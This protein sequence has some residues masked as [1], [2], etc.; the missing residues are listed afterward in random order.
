MDVTEAFENY[1]L[2]EKP[3][4]VL[5]KYYVK[6]ADEE[7]NYKI[8]YEPDGFFMTLKSKVAKKLP[9]LDTSV[10]WKSKLCIDLLI[11]GFIVSS[12]LA[13]KYDWIVA[14]IIFMLCAAQFGALMNAA[15][16]NFMH[17]RNNWRMYASN[18]VMVSFRDWR[19]FHGIVSV[20]C[21][22]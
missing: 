22:I 7:R 11:L 20:I 14:K 18:L 4:Q 21:H 19:V 10:S 3:S 8:T 16:H 1:H 9:M 13:V 17:Q 15:S 6:D 5:S 2:T 12:I